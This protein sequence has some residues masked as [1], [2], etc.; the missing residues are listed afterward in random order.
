MIVCLLVDY[1]IIAEWGMDLA[2]AAE[3][4]RVADPPRGTGN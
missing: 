3:P 2:V 1:Y 4:Y